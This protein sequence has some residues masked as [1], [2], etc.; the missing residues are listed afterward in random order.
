M[1]KNKISDLRDHL[2]E[3]LEALKDTDN[4]MDVDRAKAITNVA[5]AIINTAKVEVDLVRAVG[6]DGSAGTFFEL[7]TDRDVSKHARAIDERKRIAEGKKA[8]S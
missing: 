2:F 6:G 1:A 8:V 3:T 7:P 4:P 5:Q